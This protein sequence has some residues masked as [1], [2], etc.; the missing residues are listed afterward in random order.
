[1][2]NCNARSLEVII[3][4]DFISGTALVKDPRP[5]GGIPIFMHDGFNGTVRRNMKQVYIDA[6][7]D[8]LE[9]FWN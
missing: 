3:R 4:D 6:A 9:I 5:P 7:E 2:L 1:M 8:P